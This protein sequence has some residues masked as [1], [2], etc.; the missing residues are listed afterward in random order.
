VT[1]LV[2]TFCC[3]FAIHSHR[4]ND[5]K[6][7][8]ASESTIIESADD[9]E[10]A[11]SEHI[12][13][14]DAI[15]VWS[16]RLRCIVNVARCCVC[17]VLGGK[18]ILPENLQ[19]VARILVQLFHHD[20]FLDIVPGD[21]LAGLMLVGWEQCAA[22]SSASVEDTS[23]SSSSSQRVNPLSAE[24]VVDTKIESTDSET[25]SS[26]NDSPATTAEGQISP[27]PVSPRNL[28]RD[29]T[30][31]PRGSKKARELRGQFRLVGNDHIG[32]EVRRNVKIVARSTRRELDK[33][34][35]D[36]R[37]LVEDASDFMPYCLGVYS[38]FMLALI[39]P[40]TFSC[41]ICGTGI[42]NCGEHAA[43]VVDGDCCSWHKSAVKHHLRF[44]DPHRAELVYGNFNNTVL[45]SPF[46]VFLDHKKRRVIVAIR[47]TLSIEDA[48]KDASADVVEMAAIGE[49]WGFDG[50]EKFTHRGFLEAADH[51][52]DRLEELKLL[53]QYLF[54]PSATDSD[55]NSPQLYVVGHSLGA[56][57]ATLL[58]FMLQAK[59]PAVR[60]VAFAAPSSLDQ[61][62]AVECSEF[63][64]SV[65]VGDDIVPSITLPAVNHLRDNVLDALARVKVN[66]STIFRSRQ[67][68]FNGDTF[69]YKPEDVPDSDFKRCV[70]AYKS[71]VL[72]RHDDKP[73]LA[74]PGRIVHVAATIVQQPLCFG[75]WS[76]EIHEFKAYETTWESF[77]EISVNKNA[78]KHHWPDFYTDVLTG[79]RVDWDSEGVAAVL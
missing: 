32:G 75:L 27:R 5:P 47:G 12:H 8:S 65:I 13:D 25:N 55:G 6:R 36:D 34:S 21:A 43:G 71:K 31:Q 57:L 24:L 18:R 61:V 76:E 38:A 9:I 17:G 41:R 42:S 1:D 16:R 37:Q 22:H 2:L 3:C 79:I 46:C 35:A 30:P 54:G 69:F 49:K 28:L 33:R 26:P 48:I 72:K 29:V 73:Q 7:K 68:D 44:V 19:A 15:E 14:E 74:L 11:N 56:A 60:C 52:R 23:F 39:N 10:A 70:D 20:G 53:D 58:T 59:Y 77:I 63:V 67:A 78:V 64:T 4:M 40:C 50:R 45:L 66:K 62:T 51:I